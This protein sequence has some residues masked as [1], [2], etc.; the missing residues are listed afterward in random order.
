[1]GGLIVQSRVHGDCLAGGGW[2]LVR[3]ATGGTIL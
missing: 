2:G 3:V 1:M